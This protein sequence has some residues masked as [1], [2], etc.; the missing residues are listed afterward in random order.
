MVKQ[1]GSSISGAFKKWDHK[2]EGTVPRET[3]VSLLKGL[4]F[5]PDEIDR[6]LDS[7]FKRQVADSN[8][9]TPSIK[10]D[11]FVQWIVSVRANGGSTLLGS[12]PMTAKPPSKPQKKKFFIGAN[13]KCSLEGPN[14]VDA[15]VRQLNSLWVSKAGSL[16]DVELCLYPPYVFLDRVRD[17]LSAELCVGGQNAWDA[18]P[19]FA[20][21]GVVTAD[22]LRDVGCSWVLL[23]HSDRRNVLGESD[24]YIAEKVAKCFASGLNVNL[25]I[26]EKLE[27]REAGRALDVLVMQLGAAAAG[28]PSDG[29]DRVVVAYEPVWAIGE[30]AQPCS[31]EET[32]RV[33]SALR[34]W[35]KEHVSEIAARSCRLVYTGS[36]NEGNA[37]QFA[38]LPDVDGFV[39]GRAGLD[40]EK[41]LSICSTLV[42]R[43]APERPQV[44]PK[45]WVGANWK[46]SIQT[47]QGADALVAQINEAWAQETGTLSDVELCLFPP[48]AYLDRV[49][50]KLR[51][52]LHVGSQNAWDAKPGFNST[53]VISAEMLNSVGCKWVLLG[54][55]D[56]RNV[57]LEADGLIAE[58]MARCLARG[59]SVNLTIGEKLEERQAGKAIET[60]LRQLEAGT[61][62][63]PADAWSRVAVSYE[64]V[65]AIGEGATPCSPEDAQAV[66]AALRGWVRDHA[67]DEAARQ[68]RLIYTGSVSAESAAQYARLPDVD[69]FV[70]GR[71]G[72]DVAKLLSICKTLAAVKAEE[73]AAADKLK[74][75]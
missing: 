11:D 70:V 73:C 37:A 34:G 1:L 61:T 72:L 32:Q 29:W 58:K 4:G 28:V 14:E 63:V 60:L 65:W 35:L 10:Y 21:T 33:H 52:Q 38:Q 56:R 62:G 64:P 6:L 41:L 67:G 27:D 50:R 55:S 54:H 24:A 45:F 8:G 51:G 9:A 44:K 18:A 68:C 19:G 66:H 31:P 53:G 36:V 22:M 23:G 13:W 20:S 43:K 7:Y 2:E 30:G 12:A 71:A 57:L 46:C 59:L 26:G 15:L 42:E 5:G 39:V 40:A 3:M 48:Y 49:R 74:G 69:G 75:V 16:D 25:T 47:S 17:Q